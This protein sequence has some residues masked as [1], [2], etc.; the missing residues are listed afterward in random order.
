MWICVFKDEPLKYLITQ[1]ELRSRS[2]WHYG[3]ARKLIDKNYECS[4]AS[5]TEELYGNFAKQIREANQGK[6]KVGYL[7]ALNNPRYSRATL[8]SLVLAVSLQGT[9]INAINVYS[10]S[11]Y[12]DL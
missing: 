12:R 8:I 10:T 2:S 5:Q 7:G 11:I 3:A 4:D 9:G 1:A 6:E